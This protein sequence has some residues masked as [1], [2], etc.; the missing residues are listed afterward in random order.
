M[1]LDIKSDINTKL[2]NTKKFA[3]VANFVKLYNIM[4]LKSYDKVIADLQAKKLY[5]AYKSKY[6]G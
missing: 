4:T 5:A 1:S 3:K 2:L 6:D